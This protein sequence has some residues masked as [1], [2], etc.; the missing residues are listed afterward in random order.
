[1][2]PIQPVVAPRDLIGAPN[3]RLNPSILTP[4]TPVKSRGWSMHHLAA[5]A[6]EAMRADAWRDGVLL[7]VSGNPYRD[8]AGQERMFRQ[9]YTSTTPTRLDARGR[10]WNGVR[11]Y[12]TSGAAAAVPGTSNHGLGLAIDIALD[13]NGDEKF[14]WPVKPLDRRALAWLMEHAADYGFSWEVQSEPWHLRYVI[15]DTLPP[16]L[17]T[18]LPP[19][20][21]TPQT[22]TVVRGDSWWGLSQRYLGSGLRYRDLQRMN[23]GVSLHPGV[24]LRV[25]EIAAPVPEVVP[26]RTHKVRLGESYWTIAQRYYGRG[27][28][29]PEISAANGHKTLRPGMV[30]R[31][32]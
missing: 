12:R 7:S 2:F 3:G 4:V 10:V 30:V 22:H 28:R 8:Y 18:T 14:E 9:R 26:E 16:A 29:W 1:M 23:P 6:W 31:V 24:V 15:G 21:I 27:A 11:Y 13:A 20:S 32:P 17:Q 19:V 25:G 5:R